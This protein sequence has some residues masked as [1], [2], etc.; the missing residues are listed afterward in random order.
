MSELDRIVNIVITR[1]TT[2]IAS[3]NFSTPLFVSKTALDAGVEVFTSAKA[4]AEDGGYAT[5]SPEYL[6][7]LA[8]FNVENHPPEF[9][10]AKWDDVTYPSISDAL[11]AI[12]NIDNDWYGLLLSEATDASADTIYSSMG[13][14][15]DA[16]GKFLFGAE[17]DKTGLATLTAMNG[18]DAKNQMCFVNTSIRSGQD[19]KSYADVAFAS[20]T[21]GRRIGSYTM[22]NKTIKGVVADKLTSTEQDAIK[23]LNGMYYITTY[24]VGLTVN[25]RC[26]DGT[27]NGEWIDVEIGI[28]WTE[29]RMQEAVFQTIINADKI[30]YTDK[31]VNEIANSVKDILELGEKYGLFATWSVATEPVAD[32]TAEDKANRVYNGCSWNATLAGAIHSVTIY[33]N[34]EVS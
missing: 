21:L 24:G 14:W 29:V 23:A 15:A 6:A 33:G 22:E 34:V 28:D 1:D 9:K 31:G 10:I 16:N 7:A 2:A 13:I 3:A 25:A 17:D 12:V 32:Q 26:T 20:D 19:V 27:A 4:V 11:N 5:T 30:P 18:T 8:H